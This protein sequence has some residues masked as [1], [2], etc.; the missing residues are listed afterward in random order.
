LIR[1]PIFISDCGLGG[2]AKTRL[3]SCSS[4][5]SSSS[6]A[7]SAMSPQ[8]PPLDDVYRML[9]RITMVW[10]HMDTSLDFCNFDLYHDH[11]G[12][13]IDAELPRTALSR[14]IEF[15]RKAVA[16]SE[17]S[18]EHKAFGV[19]LSAELLALSGDRRWMIHGVVSRTDESGVYTQMRSRLPRREPFQVRDVTEEHIEVI[20]LR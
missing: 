15:F 11:G 17:L 13:A 3:A 1:F 9:G 10:S 14:K 12:R 7:E 18:A 2:I 6:F 4:L 20:I 5:R 19:E 8:R 16:A